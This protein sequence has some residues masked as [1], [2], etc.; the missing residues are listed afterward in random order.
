MI[1]KKSFV[2]QSQRIFAER[3]LVNGRLRNTTNI[4]AENDTWIKGIA[5]LPMH[6]N[7]TQLC[8]WHPAPVALPED[9][10]C[11]YIFENQMI[12][13][14]DMTSP[15][16]DLGEDATGDADGYD[17]LD[18]VVLGVK[19]DPQTMAIGMPLVN[20]TDSAACY[21]KRN[22][23]SNG[24]I[25]R[26]IDSDIGESSGCTATDGTNDGFDYKD[27]CLSF[28]F[29]GNNNNIVTASYRCV[30]DVANTWATKECFSDSP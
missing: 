3:I 27:G 19:D 11:E 14:M 8:F 23:E 22:G 12:G 4:S 16:V 24:T 1:Q 30:D 18:M 15:P 29:D 7:G 5:N 20:I 13:G 6:L 2:R 25:Y 21:D 10:W 26:Y 9:Y 28:N 17:Y